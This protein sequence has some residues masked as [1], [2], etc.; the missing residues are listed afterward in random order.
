[1]EDQGSQLVGDLL[2][3]LEDEAGNDGDSGSRYKWV[4]RGT[5]PTQGMLSIVNPCV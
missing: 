4:K 3:Y 1:M 2:G 5:R